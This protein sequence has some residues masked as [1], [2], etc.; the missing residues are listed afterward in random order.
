MG[1]RVVGRQPQRYRA[2]GTTDLTWRVHTDRMH[3]RLRTAHLYLKRYLA[4]PLVWWLVPWGSV[5]TL[6]PVRHERGDLDLAGFVD[7]YWCPACS[8]QVQQ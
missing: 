4:D 5:D 8:G 6:Y 1:T 7:A 3:G 2:P